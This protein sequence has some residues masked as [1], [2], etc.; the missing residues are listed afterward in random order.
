M[1][2]LPISRLIHVSVNLTPSGASTQ[3]ISTLLILGTSTV[4]D[5]FE[6]IRNYSDIESVAADFGTSAPEYAAALLWFEQVPQPSQISIGRWAKTASSGGLRC[7]TLAPA[8]QAIGSWQAITTGSFKV[9]VDAAPAA[10]ITGLNFAAAANLN[11]VAA[12]IDTALAGG[13]VV[14]NATYS[15]FE[16]TSSATG[17]TSAIS[18]LQAAATG[19]DISAKLA[20]RSTSSG[21]YVFQG[22]AAQSA[23]ETVTLFELNY[24]QTWYAT[25]LLGSDNADHLAVAPFIEATNTKHIYVITTQEA[26]VLVPSDTTNIAYLLKQLG[27]KRSF[28][29]YSSGNPYAAVSAIARLL[30]VDYNG[31]STVITLMYKQEPGIVPENLN[32][33]QINALESFNCNVFVQY[34]NDTAILERGTMADGTFADIITGTDW[35]ALN[36]Q[37]NV[38][39]LLYTSPTKIPQTNAGMQLI[40]TQIQAVLSQAVINGLIAPGVWNSGGFGQLKQG[41]YLATGFYIYAPNVDSQSQADRAARKSVPFQIAV[42]LAGAVHEVSIAILVNQ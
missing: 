12:I 11:A 6:R 2:Q 26:G 25:T 38:Y 37:T 24:G 23:L 30:T 41:D 4:I 27:Y 20:G 32:G 42:K 22:T 14:W 9:A 8:D 40:A 19:V 10:D 36:I 39:N 17:V 33:V 34:D 28:V 1:N 31:N 13:T 5:T 35:L 29:Q 18:F 21:A 7:G 16:F 3:D 15:R